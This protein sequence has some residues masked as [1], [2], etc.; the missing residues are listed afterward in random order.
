MTQEFMSAEHN[1]MDELVNI[2]YNIE[3]SKSNYE[4]QMVES[5]RTKLDPNSN[6]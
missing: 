3:E 1:T 4:W 5:G 2:I 6:T